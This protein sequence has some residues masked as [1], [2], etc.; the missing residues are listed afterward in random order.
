MNKFIQFTP[1]EAVEQSVSNKR[2]LTGFILAVLLVLSCSFRVAIAQETLTWKD[3]VREAA[4]NHPDLIAAE[5]S[6]KQSEAGKKIAASIFYPQVSSDV[7]VERT[8]VSSSGKTA[9]TTNSYTYGLTAAQLLFDGFKTP[10]NVKAA[11]ENIKAAQYNYRFTSSQVRLR[12]RGAFINL[13]RAQELLNITQEIYNIRRSN[14][15]LITLRYESG[16]EHKG[17]LMTAEANAAQAKFE[18]AQAKRTLETV[19]RQLHKEMGRTRFSPLSVEG[20]FEVRDRV[21]EK[22]DFEALASTHPSL[23]RLAAQK[24]AAFFGIKAAEAN[25]FPQFSAQ[26]GANKNSAHWPPENDQWNTGITLSLPLFEGGLRLAETV[27][28]KSV[29]NQLRA[30]EQSAKDGFITAL[31]QSWAALQDAVDTVEVQ[32][33]FLD[34]AEERSHIARAQYSL[35][36]IQFDGWT[37]IEDNLVRTKKSFLDA[38]SGALLAEADWF[39]AKGETLEYAD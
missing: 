2:L 24:N 7:S 27:Q 30:N 39:Q 4:K 21:L 38:Q 14:L 17:A 10:N 37:I 13:L 8:S 34:A 29:F 5:E 20:D 31:E 12:L 35:G 16:I 11:L 9:K 23:N 32:K 26:A 18:I 28:A 19:Q 6:L 15:E 1:L 33:R 36:L 3:C 22:P 25:F